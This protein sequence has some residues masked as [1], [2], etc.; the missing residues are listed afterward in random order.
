ME[1]LPI[2]V[3]KG[4]LVGYPILD[5][6]NFFRDIHKYLRF[7]E[8]AIINTLAHFEIKGERYEGLTGVWI[9]P[10][11]GKARKI[12]AIGVKTGR[13][14]TMHGFALN[15]NTDLSYFDYIVPCGIDDKEPLPVTEKELW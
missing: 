12:C 8:E 2:T 13:W 3:Q 6:D 10:D 9:E 7:I 15:V 5:F 11:T 14:V 4:N 1:I